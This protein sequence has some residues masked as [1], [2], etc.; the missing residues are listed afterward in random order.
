MKN[1]MDESFLLSTE[2]AENLYHKYA[3]YLPV[4]DYHCHVNPQ[5]IAENRKAENIT[6][7]WLGGDHYKWRLMRAC[8]VPE[9]EI[10][11]DA[12]DKT[13]FLRFAEVLPRAVGNPVY[14][15]AHLELKRYFGFDGALTPETAEE[16]WNL[17][18]EKLK[19]LSVRE[20]IKQSNVEVI[21]STDDPIDDLK[22]HKMLAEDSSFDVKVLPG[23]RPDKAM[24]IERPEFAD[25]ISKLAEVSG[26]GIKSFADL[27]KALTNRLE[28]FHENSCVVSDHGMDFVMH[29]PAS[30]EEIES[31]ISKKF[32]GET[33]SNDEVSKFKYAV[34]VYLGKEYSR[35]GWILQIHYGAVRNTN[36]KMFAKL[37]PDTGYDCIGNSGNAFSISALLNELESTNELPKTILYS[38]NPNDDAMLQTVA[39]CFQAEGIRGKVQH[40]SAWW[41]NDTKPGMQRQLESFASETV[42]GNFVGMLTDSR[43]FLSYTRHEYF[44]RILCEIIGNWVENGE[45]PNDIDT[46]GQIVADISYNNARIFFGF[47]K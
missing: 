15:W 46:L 47:N 35:L 41:F 25:Y 21:V 3:A 11:G 17:A 6:Q 4:I 28:F 27:K 20:I 5:E 1:F 16:V 30:D 9:N 32:A 2:T 43:S 29:S 10:T 39:G 26:C 42:L 40:G 19:K 7:L 34:L 38:L 45:L 14:H 31:I 44:R 22:W 33:L 24:N 36:S 13:K 23:W 18:E 12:D 37:G 8:G